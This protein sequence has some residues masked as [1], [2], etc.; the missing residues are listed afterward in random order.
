MNAVS[1]GKILAIDVGTVRV[2]LALGLMSFGI[3]NPL[4]TIPARTAMEDIGIIMDLEGI[5]EVVVGYPRNQSGDS[6]SMSLY[7]EDFVK[8]L[9]QTF[10]GTV[11]HMQDESVTSILAEERLK[12]SVKQYEKGDIDAMAACLILE[13]YIKETRVS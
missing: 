12:K 2:G 6:T 3:A 8:E 13:D 9:K 10:P 1:S 4:K 7:V 11:V 5:S